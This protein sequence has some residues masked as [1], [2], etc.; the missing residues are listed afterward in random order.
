VPNAVLGDMNYEHEFTNETYVDLGNGMKFPTVCHSHEGWDD[1]SQSQSISA[2]HN[3]FRGPLK[4]VKANTSVDPVTVPESVRQATFPVRVETRKLA[5]GVFL[6]GGSTHNSVA[7]EFKD[8]VAVIE[9]PLDEKRNL[10]VIEEI[11]KLIPNKPIRFVVNT[12]QHYD[13]AGGLRTFMHIGAT[14]ITHEHNFEFYRR[15]VLNYAP[16]TLQPDML[17]LW[18]PTEMAEG[19]QYET[20]RENYVLSNGDRNLHIFY[21]NPIRHVEGMLMAYLPK[22]KM[23]F[24]ADLVDS[25]APLPSTASRD[26]RSF[27]RAVQKLKLDVS[28]VVPIHGQPFSWADF[29]RI[30]GTN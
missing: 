3:A 20:V 25:I 30:A 24:E 18:P 1:N 6:L 14:I 28:Q 16:R 23:L 4:D 13:H 21:V 17:A 22:E 26:Q 29:A 2:G 19:Y 11:V 10:A 9:A 8:Y 15:D 12:H 7:I 27:F 5:D